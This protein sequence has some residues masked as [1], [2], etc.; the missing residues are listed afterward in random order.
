MFAQNLLQ[1]VL[2]KRLHVLMPQQRRSQLHLL[3]APNQEQ[4]PVRAILRA[5]TEIPAGIILARRASCFQIRRHHCA[6]LQA[7]V[8][9]NA[10]HLQVQAAAHDDLLQLLHIY[11][12]ID[13]NISLKL[14]MLYIYD[15]NFI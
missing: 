2:R 5:L 8:A 13:C 11:I 4:L 10:R 14:N 6:Q 7:M 12:Y 1:E 9:C 3:T 15:N